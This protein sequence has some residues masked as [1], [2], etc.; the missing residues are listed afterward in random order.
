[1]AL[2]ATPPPWRCQEKANSLSLMAPV[3]VTILW[4]TGLV[5]LNAI[6]FPST[7]PSKISY[8]PGPEEQEL[9]APNSLGPSAMRTAFHGNGFP[10]P[11]TIHVPVGPV[12][13]AAS[14]GASRSAT[15]NKEYF[16]PSSPFLRMV[17]VLSGKQYIPL[18]L[19]LHSCHF[20]GGYGDSVA[21]R[22][23]GSAGSARR[24]AHATAP[25]EGAEDLQ[26][27]ECDLPYA[28]G[29]RG[30]GAGEGVLHAEAHP[31]EDVG[32][33]GGGGLDGDDGA[34]LG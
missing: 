13:A 10:T 18:R 25:V 28:G 14:R 29:A 21:A 15:A 33:I 2:L 11:S 26:L 3:N 31:F 5:H 30:D 32:G 22:T 12:C 6:A 24:D 9:T 34:L 19:W 1:M 4:P 20:V 16:I 7:L 27:L 17:R 23:G 8:A